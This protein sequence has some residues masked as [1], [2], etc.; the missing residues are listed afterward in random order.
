[1]HLEAKA[2]SLRE[3]ITRGFLSGMKE[4]G[5]SCSKILTATRALW[6]KWQ[7]GRCWQRG[8]VSGKNK[9]NLVSRSA[10]EEADSF[11][12][13]MGEIQE[14]DVHLRSLKTN[15][16][17]LMDLIRYIKNCPRDRG[18]EELRGNLGRKALVGCNPIM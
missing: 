16:D 2:R 18:D 10:L 6:P 13:K 9:G 7:D 14:V 5:R 12:E 4:P 17:K 1:M 15:R 3:G 11:V 8:D